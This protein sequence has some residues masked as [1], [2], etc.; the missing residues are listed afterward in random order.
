MLFISITVE[1]VLLDDP[2]FCCFL[3]VGWLCIW[4]LVALDIDSFKEEDVRSAKLQKH[5]RELSEQLYRNVRLCASN[6]NYIF[7]AVSVLYHT[8]CI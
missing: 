1:C 4:Q 2:L 6:Y 3:F 7:S 8:Y 5:I